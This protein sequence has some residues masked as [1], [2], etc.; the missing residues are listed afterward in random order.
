LNERGLHVQTGLDRDG[1]D[2]IEIQRHAD[3]NPKRF[4]AEYQSRVAAN[5]ALLQAG[6]EARQRASTTGRMAR[7]EVRLAAFDVELETRLA[8]V[9]AA[10]A[11]AVPEASPSSSSSEGEELEDTPTEVAEQL[12]RQQND[13][14]PSGAFNTPASPKIPAHLLQQVLELNDGS[15]LEPARADE[16]SEG[17]VD[18]TAPDAFSEQED[19]DGD[20]NNDEYSNGDLYS[21]A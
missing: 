9:A 11:V 13:R 2:R 15:L 6:E 4:Q 1:R 18:N 3:E 5:Q 8:E 12:V 21:P 16:P 14:F 20:G 7:A 10:R 17:E 19:E